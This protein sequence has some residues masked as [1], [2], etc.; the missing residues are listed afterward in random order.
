MV[1][2]PAPVPTTFP[3][4]LPT[5]AIAVLLLLHVPPVIEAVKIALLPTQIF[6]V[7]D[8]ET[9]VVLTVTTLVA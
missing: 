3:V 9:G 7:P 4:E 2:V 5:V 8:M 1:A 6:T